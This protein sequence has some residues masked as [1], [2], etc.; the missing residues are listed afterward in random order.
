LKV[1]IGGTF[2][3][4][5]RGHELLFEKAFELGSRV[6]IGLSSDEMIKG[7]KEVAVDDYEARKK[8]LDNFLMGMGWGD[9]YSIV[10]IESELGTAADKDFDA[11][12]VSEETV[13]GAEKINKKR[14]ENGFKPLEI[15][16]VKMALAENGETISATKIK[17]GEMDANGQLMKKVVVFVGSTNIVK[18]NAASNVFSKLFRR[19]QVDGMNV[20]T[21][22][23]EQPMEDEVI[24]GAIE[25]AQAAMT[26][27]CDFGVGIEAGLFWN[28]SAK[29]YFDV[30]YCAVIDKAKRITLGHGSG[31]YYPPEIIEL[32]KGGKTVGQSMEQKYG[33]KDI[34]KKKG[35]IGYLT[36]DTLDRTKLTEQAVLMAM[37]PRIRSELYEG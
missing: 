35:A 9:Q 8:N 32:V 7:S 1:C 20:K 12:V 3:I 31:F 21:D 23:P 5:H 17:K 33:T 26:G 37:I 25:R 14:V 11:I 36:K 27:E 24:N 29:Q 4:L 13:K 16:P 15:F 18:I 19:V 30:Q 10:K 22:V 28:E 34:G 2:N 6:F